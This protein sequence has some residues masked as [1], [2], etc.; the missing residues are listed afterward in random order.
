V[1]YIVNSIKIKP[2]IRRSWSV[3]PYIFIIVTSV[4]KNENEMSIVLGHLCAHVLR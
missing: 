4:E 3:D 1:I 2:F